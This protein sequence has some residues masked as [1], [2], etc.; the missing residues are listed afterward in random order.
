[1]KA[2]ST[3]NDEP[4]AA[5]AGPFDDERDGFVMGEGAGILVL[6]ELEHA[7]RRGARD[8]RRG[9]RLRRRPATPTTSPRRRPTARA[10]RAACAWRSTTRGSRRAMSTTSTPTAPR[11][12]STT[13][14]DRGDQD[15][16]RRARAASWRS[17]STKS[18]TGHLLGAAGGVEAIVVGAGDRSTASSRRRSTTSTP[19]P[20]AT[21]TT[22]RTRRAACAVRD[23]AV[24]LLRFRRH[25]RLPHLQKVRTVTGGA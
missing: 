15:G 9:R 10:R 20:S 24:E 16:L 3:R 8:L 6:E 12:R 5:P 17:S 14:R 2:L 13:R 18:M 22:C 21:S 4:D 23:R 11:R 7:Q 25:Q 1:M 19:T